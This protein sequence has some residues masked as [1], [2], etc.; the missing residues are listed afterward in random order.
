M[1]WRPRHV[2]WSRIA[3]NALADL[4]RREPSR[5]A[6]IRS[7]VRSYAETGAGDV[8]KLEGRPN[9]YRLRVGA[10]RV[11]FSFATEGELSAPTLN[12]LRIADRRDTYRD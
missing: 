10:W 8:R 3:T 5:A 7:R 4:S 1:N 2:R 12:V 11:L 9:E 6:A